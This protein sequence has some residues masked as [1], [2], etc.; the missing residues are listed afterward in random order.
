MPRKQYVQQKKRILKKSTKYCRKGKA[1]KSKHLCRAMGIAFK[2][3]EKRVSYVLVCITFF[4][5]FYPDRWHVCY[6]CTSKQ[7]RKLSTFMQLIDN[8]F[9]A[10]ILTA[11]E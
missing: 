11:N 10:N 2:A 1:E 9:S 8:L 7:F 3:L 6:T 5:R 4:A